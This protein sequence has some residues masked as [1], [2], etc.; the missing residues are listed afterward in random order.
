[1]KSLLQTGP[2]WLAVLLSITLAACGGTASAEPTP[3]TIHYGED[4]CDICNMIISEE[5]YAAAY[6][7]RDGQGHVFDDIGDMVLSYIQQEEDNDVAAFFV[8]DYEDKSWIRAETASFV[9]SDALHTP[10]FSGLAACASRETAQTLAA[11]LPGKVLTFDQVL[12]RYQDMGSMS[13]EKGGNHS[14]HQ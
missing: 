3:P 1:M 4:T 6:V 11:E 8:H 9:L 5:R 2:W 14:S 13:M 10:M 12:A 7:T